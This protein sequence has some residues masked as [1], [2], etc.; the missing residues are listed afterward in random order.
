MIKKIIFHWP[1]LI[2]LLVWWQF[3]TIS[4]Y[5]NPYGWFI[6]GIIIIYYMIR[7]GLHVFFLYQLNQSDSV[8]TVRVI[9]P[10]A[11]KKVSTEMIHFFEFLNTLLLPK[12]PWQYYVNGV[13]SFTWEVQLDAKGNKEILISASPFILPEILKNLQTIYEN[14]RFETVKSEL[15]HQPPQEFM[16]LRLEHPGELESFSERKFMDQLFQT[17]DE[18]KGE[19]GIQVMLIPVDYQTQRRQL[20]RKGMD[21]LF[22]TEIR[23]YASNQQLLKALLGTIGEL[24][25]QNRLIPE[26]IISYQIRKWFKKHYWDLVINKY[27]SLFLG[28]RVV[29]SSNQLAS[30][31]HFPSSILWVRGTYR[32]QHRR[33]PVPQGLPVNQEVVSPIAVT[34]ENVEVGLTDEMWKQHLLVVGTGG[35]G[36]TTTLGQHASAWFSRPDEGALVIG[37]QPHELMFILQFVPDYKKVY[38]ID[39]DKPSKYGINFLS[40]DAYP[41]DMMVEDFIGIFDPPFAAQIK[42]MDFIQQAFLA[43][44]QARE[45][46]IVWKEAVPRIDLRHIREVLANEKYRMNL[47]HVL[48]QNSDLQLYWIE[49]TQLMRNPRYYVTYVQPIIGVFNRI[50]G[51]ERVAKTLCHPN[52]ID[53]KKAILEEKAVVALHGGKWDYGFNVSDFAGNMLLTLLYQSILHQRDIPEEKRVNINLILDDFGGFCSRILMMLLV[54][55][56]RMN[57]RIACA[58]GTWFDVPES[59]RTFFDDLILNKI[60]FRGHNH[61]DADYWGGLMDKLEP[62]DFL[63]MKHRYGA[64]WFHANGSQQDPFIARAIY[65]QHKGRFEQ[66]HL[67]HNWPTE[68]LQLQL[69][70]LM[71]PNIPGTQIKPY[72]PN[73]SGKNKNQF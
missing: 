1:L 72:L 71:M 73:M 31:L 33:L 44:R 40:N 11:E 16:Q 60:I 29:L 58:A 53:L 21:A 13:N 69:D 20:K 32:Y 5:L 18:L 23:I 50:L 39:M 48:P 17:V 63:N 34:D 65:D 37:S 47:I 61:R 14:A 26:G 70:P 56:S 28:P 66:Y 55:S 27:F 6:L 54:R 3:D 49:K 15:T 24:S 4:P 64:F 38:I 59:M 45:Q 52:T 12:F 30:L 36:K 2:L 7:L 57:V 22:N 67:T 25:P 41:V 8:E 43:L 51:V 46:S 19:A 9:L 42:N 10:R 68:D 35:T 62:E